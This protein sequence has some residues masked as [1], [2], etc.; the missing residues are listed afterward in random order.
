MPVLRGVVVTKYLYTISPL[1]CPH[2]TGIHSNVNEF[3]CRSV[4][5]KSPGAL[6][7]TAKRYHEPSG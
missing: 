1:L 5:F 4:A 3:S 2:E 6:F 7:G